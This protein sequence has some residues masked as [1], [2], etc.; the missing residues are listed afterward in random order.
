[1]L[2]KTTQAQFEELHQAV[3]GK[4][5]S[6]RVDAQAL[7]NLLIDHSTL[8]REARVKGLKIQEAEVGARQKLDL[9]R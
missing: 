7:T 9:T 8:I 6:I 1:M 4:A 3:S 2:L 5:K